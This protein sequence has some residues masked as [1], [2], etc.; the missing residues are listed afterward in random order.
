[1]GKKTKKVN[2]DAASAGV[3]T[4]SFP[5]QLTPSG[6]RHRN[7]PHPVI[8]GQALTD[9]QRIDNLESSVN[10]LTTALDTVA[11]RKCS[12]DVAERVFNQRIQIVWKAIRDIR[13]YHFSYDEEDEIGHV[14]SDPVLVKTIE[15]NN[16]ARV[17]VE[18]GLSGRMRRLEKALEERFEQSG[19]VEA[20]TTIST[21]KGAEGKEAADKAK[22]TV[23]DL[24][25]KG[26]IA[27]LVSRIDALQA[28]HKKSIRALKKRL[29][30]TV[31]DHAK[32]YKESQGQVVEM[33]GMVEALEGK[34][35]KMAKKAKKAGASVEAFE[36]AQSMMIP[37]GAPTVSHNAASS[38]FEQV[39]E[40]NHTPAHDTKHNERT[41]ALQPV[42]PEVLPVSNDKASPEASVANK[43][44]DK[45]VR[46]IGR[47][48][49]AR[50]QADIGKAMTKKQSRVMRDNNE[51]INDVA[52]AHFARRSA[53]VDTD[54][55]IAVRE[56]DDA[57]AADA[58]P[59]PGHG[60][61]S[62]QTLLPSS[63]ATHSDASAPPT[64]AA[65]SAEG[66][67]E[68][69]AHNVDIKA[70]AITEV[71]NEIE[72]AS[73]SIS[74]SVPMLSGRQNGETRLSSQDGSSTLA[75]A[76]HRATSID[77]AGLLQMVDEARNLH[78]H[79]LKQADRLDETMLAFEGRVKDMLAD[80]SGKA[81]PP[82]RTPE[83]SGRR[84]RLQARTT[85]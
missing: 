37:Q 18:Q 10:W 42:E 83:L 47:Y 68:D 77:E 2:Q 21:G 76:D 1:M 14:L 38:M 73:H 82:A 34:L 81:V 62:D 27:N 50:V 39:D 3:K 85:V 30:D 5:L 54:P 25:E 16:Q 15:R 44:H 55:S 46:D 28:S 64:G 61:E 58:P 6:P 48:V 45:L 66:A 35:A 22:D 65:L 57:S 36:L 75:A 11:A 31:V 79:V 9:K 8:Y 29:E 19:A 13:S 20:T 52:V 17:A 4:Q 33:K 72:V 12:P 23:A 26:T 80:K 59:A 49:A 53:V 41:S 84:A 32:Q 70:L 78:V 60:P 56:H 69:P 74:A 51:A 43:S 40:Q 71:P 67:H 7:Q 63:E 24:V